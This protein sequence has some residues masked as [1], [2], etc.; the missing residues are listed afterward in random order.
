MLKEILIYAPNISKENLQGLLYLQ[1]GCLGNKISVNLIKRKT[2]FRAPELAVICEDVDANEIANLLAHV[3]DV[4]KTLGGTRFVYLQD[5]KPVSQLDA[6]D[7][8]EKV[9]AILENVSAETIDKI[10]IY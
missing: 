9:R 10:E 2:K 6:N 7:Q 8:P 1:I 4:A 3:F 5:N